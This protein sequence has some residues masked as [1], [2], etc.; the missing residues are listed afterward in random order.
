[1]KM[2]L[3]R[4]V[5]GK[6]HSVFILEKPPSSERKARLPEKDIFGIPI[7]ARINSLDMYKRSSGN[8]RLGRYDCNVHG[9]WGL[10]EFDTNG[11]ATDLAIEALEKASAGSLLRDF[12]VVEPGIGLAALWATKV[13]GPARLHAVSRDLLSLSATG[14][15]L[16]KALHPA[17]GPEYMT[18]ESGE[19][20]DLPEASIDSILIFPESI[21]E[22]DYITPMWSQIVHCT[23]RGSSI[24]IVAT[25]TIAS[26]IEKIHPKLVRRVGEKKRKGFVAL[27][28]IRE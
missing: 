6:S 18:Y 7:Q 4:T 12:M 27:I 3:V 10:P 16:K 15:N 28:F 22:F 14:A 26:R 21:P 24:V 20:P 19:L 13:F 25:S 11:F 17:A 23:K 2:K 8:R 1:M 9:Y 5:D